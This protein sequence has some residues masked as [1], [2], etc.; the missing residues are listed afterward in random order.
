[1]EALK[2]LKGFPPPSYLYGPG[3]QTICKWKP[4]Q[5]QIL[6][7]LT[8]KYPK[9]SVSVDW[10][11]L[12]TDTLYQSLRDHCKEFTL[13]KVTRNGK[14]G[15][16]KVVYVAQRRVARIKSPEHKNSLYKKGD[17]E[18]MQAKARKQSVPEEENE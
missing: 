3:H 10:E 15:K 2:G 7:E 8:V 9:G 14:T 16:T 18:M 12:V 11:K 6:A 17:W 4:Y 13:N 1:L 5:D